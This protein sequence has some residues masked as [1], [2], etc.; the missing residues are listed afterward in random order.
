MEHGSC[1]RGFCTRKAVPAAGRVAGAGVASRG[2]LEPTPPRARGLVRS[3]W[4]LPPALQSPLLA[5]L[6]LE[7]PL[8]EPQQERQEVSDRVF[9]WIC[10]CVYVQNTCR[11]FQP[12]LSRFR[13][14]IKAEPM[15]R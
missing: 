6:I 8:C 4:A 7:G 13:T 3:E 2:L 15:V 9:F 14:F 1:D 11:Y 5:F 10:V 12:L